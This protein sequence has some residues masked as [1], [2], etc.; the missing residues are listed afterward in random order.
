MAKSGLLLF[1]EAMEKFR[2]YELQEGFERFERAAAKGHEESIWIVSVVKDAEMKKSALIEAFA[3]TEK[4]LGWFFAGELSSGRERFDF[5]KK[6]EEFL[7]VNWSGSQ[8]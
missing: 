4:P 7:N 2:P 8:M 6:S 1:H 3:K 5:C